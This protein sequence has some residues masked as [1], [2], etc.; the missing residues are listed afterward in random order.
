M[1]KRVLLATFLSLTF[2]FLWY[3]FVD[4]SQQH[5]QLPPQQTKQ[6]ILPSA[7]TK[8]VLSSQVEQNFVK[9]T[10]ETENVKIVFNKFGAGIREIYINEN[11]NGKT[12][13]SLLCKEDYD[14]LSTFPEIKYETQKIVDSKNKKLNIVFIGKTKENVIQKTYKFD[15]DNTKNLS[16]I[17]LELQLKKPEKIQLIW[18]HY[19]HTDVYTKE[20]NSAFLGYITSVNNKETVFVKKVNYEK[21]DVKNI[22]WAA[23]SGK[24]FIVSL[25]P[26][27]NVESNIVVD[28]HNKVI[29][30][31]SI[32]STEEITKYTL[33]IL[34]SPKSVQ[35]LKQAGNKLY[36]TIEWGMF[37]PLSKLFYEIL[38]FFFKIF[39]N[40]GVA[41]IG[42][43]VVLQILTFPLTYN[44]LKSTLKMKQIQPQIQLLQK[45]YKNDPKRLN[46]E[47]M[48]LY[49]EKKI[50]P[51]SGCLPLLLQIPI[52]W[53]LFTML[54]NTYDLRGAKFVL[55]I[56][57]LSQPDRLYIPTTNFGFPVLV[58]LMGV[59]MFLQQ[60]FSGSFSDPN[61]KTFAIL[62]P[63]LFTVMFY[64]FPSG[65][66]LY[67][68]INNLFT[69]GIQTIINKQIK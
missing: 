15:L 30:T 39:K 8:Q 40:F 41:I 4:K 26:Q 51:F 5:K 61:Q 60:I 54:R 59:T 20:P 45:V 49:R 3:Y 21:V 46:M 38:I 65:L 32:S 50:N 12:Q 55:W 28:K 44:S 63:I 47:I 31:I 17:E 43:T 29:K 2:L 36:Q 9:E 19:I 69:I 1:E 7:E 11:I 57:D 33:S 25:F 68:F 22:L 48:N 56:K 34:I 35:T 53:A 13:Y 18:K 52:F 24:Y 6:E 10:V 62:M 42:L 23:V 66:V 14:S 16:R 27:K 58:I 64:N 37:A 67:W